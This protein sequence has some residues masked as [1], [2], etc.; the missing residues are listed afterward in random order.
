MSSRAPVGY[1]AISTKEITTNQGFKSFI[2][3]KKYGK[4]TFTI[5]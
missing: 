5:L 3:D 1:L 4:I 2:P